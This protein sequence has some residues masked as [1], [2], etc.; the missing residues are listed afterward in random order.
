MAASRSASERR[1]LV[2][3]CEDD[4]GSEG[5]RGRT[6]SAA[7]S[8]RVGRSARGEV[9]ELDVSC[10]TARDG[11]EGGVERRCDC[12]EACGVSSWYA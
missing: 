1:E 6:G 11:E 12:H 9:D 7:R 5:L 4:G 8:G 10:L 2:F 3:V